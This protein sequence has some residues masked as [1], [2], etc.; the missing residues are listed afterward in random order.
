MNTEPLNRRSFLKSA[1]CTAAAAT[2]ALLAQTGA[3]AIPAPALAPEPLPDACHRRRNHPAFEKTLVS[4]WAMLDTL[5][6]LEDA[7]HES[8][9]CGLCEDV[10]GCGLH[11]DI[12]GVRWALETFEGILQSHAIPFPAL[13]DRDRPK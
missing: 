13:R 3:D 10:P 8:C 2:P 7:A 1:A 5:D 11:P 6:E 12:I 9:I 4:L